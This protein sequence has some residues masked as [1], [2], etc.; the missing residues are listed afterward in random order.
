MAQTRMD[1]TTASVS[2]F[3]ASR[4]PC[5]MCD[6]GCSSEKKI[7]IIIIAG[8]C[9]LQDVLYTDQLLILKVTEKK[10]YCCRLS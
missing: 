10:R 4:D 5:E 6:Y 1:Q 8:L 7:I 9:V 3:Q 2:Y